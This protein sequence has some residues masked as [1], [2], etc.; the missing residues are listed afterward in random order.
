MLLQLVEELPITSTDTRIAVAVY[1]T[2]TELEVPWQQ[3]K[4]TA[5]ESIEKMYIVGG[6]TFLA[7]ALKFAREEIFCSSRSDAF[8]YLFLLTD[9]ITGE[10]QQTGTDLQTEVD[11]LNAKNVVILTVGAQINTDTNPNDNYKLEIIQPD[12]SLRIEAATYAELPGRAS[13][14]HALI[15]EYSPVPSPVEFEACACSNGFHHPETDGKTCV[16]NQCIEF[17]PKICLNF[18][19]YFFK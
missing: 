2:T 9:G 14:F 12:S 5:I 17:L 7:D 16:M 11:E 4:T 18:F 15:C 3:N 6:G 19:S 10:N 8:K 13:E 1:S